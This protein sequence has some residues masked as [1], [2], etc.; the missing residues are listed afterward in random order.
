MAAEIV[1]SGAV[2]LLL[3]ILSAG[4]GIGLNILILLLIPAG[5]LFLFKKKIATLILAGLIFAFIGNFYFHFYK[6][7]RTENFPATGAKVTVEGV[8]LGEPKLI[9]SYF[10]VPLKLAE[11]YAGTVDLRA[12]SYLSLKYGDQ[13][14]AN[15]KV[16]EPAD[17]TSLPS[18]TAYSVEVIGENKGFP[19]KSKLL[20]IKNSAISVLKKYLSPQGSALMAGL[21]FGERSNFTD[22]FKN[23]MKLSGTTHLVALSGYNI[24]ILV[25]AMN[26]I[27]GRYLSR[28]LR[29]SV[30]LTAI[31]LFVVMVGGE[32]SVVRAAIMGSILLLAKEVGRAYSARQAIALSAMAMAIWNPLVLWNLGF[33]LSF[34]S[35]FGIVY[36]SPALQN[37]FKIKSPSV[38]MEN[39]LMTVSAQMAVLPLVINYF[40]TFSLTAILANILVLSLVPTIMFFGFFLVLAGWILPFLAFFLGFFSEI[41]LR[42]MSSVI[43]FFA[44]LHL[45]F[46]DFLKNIYFSVVYYLG[47]IILIYLP[48]RRAKQ[49]ADVKPKS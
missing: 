40:G 32:A 14:Q 28:K 1:F 42:Y 26:L 38:L 39:L 44:K 16:F 7:L 22:T 12:A 19:L 45:P 5:I 13:V 9:G 29:F 24:G 2:G 21:I 10:V 36:I 23:D 41:F 27:L 49:L 34:L 8:L 20:D 47:L 25:M 18:I 35:L 11:P 43:S 30:L 31:V 4:Y 48:Q 46:G 6:N 3:G 17:E 15:G 33:E 37:L